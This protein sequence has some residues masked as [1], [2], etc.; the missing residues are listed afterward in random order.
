M[1]KTSLLESIYSE[2]KTQILFSDCLKLRIDESRRNSI[3]CSAS[4]YSRDIDLKFIIKEGKESVEIT[5]EIEQEGY[6]DITNGFN[7]G[8]GSFSFFMKAPG[9]SLEK[10]KAKIQELFSQINDIVYDEESP[11]VDSTSDDYKGSSQDYTQGDIDNESM[12]FIEKTIQNWVENKSCNSGYR[13]TCSARDV[14]YSN[15][16]VTLN[17]TMID[18]RSHIVRKDTVEISTDE[19]G[20]YIVSSSYSDE[21]MEIEPQEVYESEYFIED[22]FAEVTK[23]IINDEI[24]KASSKVDQ[25]IKQ[26]LKQKQSEDYLNRQKEYEKSQE[27]IYMNEAAYVASLFGEEYW[28]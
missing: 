6:E 27:D 19:S 18:D 25:S 2:I 8:E 3:K 23:D 20:N 5:P 21:V 16:G 7:D 11:Y 9:K 13:L 28:D 17:V 15:T 22:Y 1:I 26:E 4:S 24:S 10:M 12:E 14:V